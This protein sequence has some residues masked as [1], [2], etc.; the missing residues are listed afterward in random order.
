MQSNI[1]NKLSKQIATLGFIG[2]LPIAPG[3]FGSAAS[4]LFVVL[5]KP[6]D[7][8]ILIILLPLFLLGC[9]TS[10]NAEKVLGKDS[11]HIVID[12]FCGYLLAVLF[13]PKNIAY[14]LAAFVLFRV[15][16]ILKPPPIRKIEKSVSGGAG[17]MFDDI[18]AAVYTNV[19]I[20]LWRY[21]IT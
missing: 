15:F 12:E 17:V 16:D 14:L 21:F 10:H 3:T 9:L 18:L 5:L 19:C 1:F 7:F 6:H 8:V 20:Q 2:F 11:G 13:I 4:L